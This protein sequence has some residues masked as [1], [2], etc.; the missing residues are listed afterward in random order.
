MS[1]PP[2]ILQAVEQALLALDNERRLIDSYRNNGNRWPPGEGKSQPF[3]HP[4]DSAEALVRLLS[5]EG[6]GLVLVRDN[7]IDL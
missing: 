5:H 4:R 7:A 3:Y 1:Y 6:I 2:H